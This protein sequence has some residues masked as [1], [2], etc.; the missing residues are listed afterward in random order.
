[1]FYILLFGILAIFLVVAGVMT[2]SRRNRE[3]RHEEQHTPRSA[4]KKRKSER[5]QS[6]HARRKRK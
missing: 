5:A 6:Q 4:R 2:I 1:M 3:M